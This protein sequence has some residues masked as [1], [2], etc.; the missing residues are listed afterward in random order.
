[1]SEHDYF[2]CQFL[3]LVPAKPEQLERANEGLVEE[4]QR[5]TP[6]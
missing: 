5:H 3:S 1:M 6:S 2:D 4:G